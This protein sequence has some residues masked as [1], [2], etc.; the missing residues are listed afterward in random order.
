M[1]E[2]H[3]HANPAATADGDSASPPRTEMIA[4]RTAITAD[5]RPVARRP[6]PPTRR[7]TPL[8]DLNRAS[9]YQAAL[10]YAARGWPVFPVAGIVGGHCGCRAGPMCDHPA[11]H[12][13]NRY[14]LNAATTDPAQV[15]RWWHTW[16]WAGVAIRTGAPS[17]LVVVDIDPAHGGLRTLDDL[18]RTGQLPTRTLDTLAVRTGGAGHHLFYQ[19]PKTTVPNTTG[20]LPSI[21]ATPGVDLRGDGGYIIAPPSPHHSGQR[22][23]WEPT[24]PA[25]A[26][27]PPWAQPAPPA[28]RQPPPRIPVVGEGRLARYAHA[29]LEREA[30]A[31]ASAPEGQRNH[32]LNRA[33]Y[34]LGTLVGAGAFDEAVV[35]TSLAHAAESAGLGPREI[36]TTIRSGLSTGIAHPRQLPAVPVETPAAVPRADR[37]RVPAPQIHLAP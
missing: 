16:P 12:P 8:V 10:A 25:P 20:Q 35:A 27:L 29:A 23:Q 17:G 7:D 24:L 37:P 14:G 33:A 32:T 3:A 2:R 5:A 11:K 21:G 22:Y 13:L 1:N 15:A 26:E 6:A 4:N 31:V 30:A 34:N 19:H 9:P 18:A 28:P 36:M